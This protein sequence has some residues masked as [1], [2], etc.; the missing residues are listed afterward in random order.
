MEQKNTIKT[1][2]MLLAP[3]LLFAILFIPYGWLNSAVIVKVFGCGCPQINEVGEMIYPKFNAND[4][5]LLFWLVVS[6]CITVISVFL[7]IKKIPSN[8]KWLR[9][10][11]VVSM[12]AVSVIISYGLYQLT[13]WN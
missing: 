11:Y 1:I 2:A 10:I 5:T 6:V 3:L 4:F 12:F 9:I 8:K 7:S 13:M